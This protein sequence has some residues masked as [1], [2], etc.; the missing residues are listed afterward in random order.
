MTARVAGYIILTFKAHREGKQY[1]ARCEELGVSTC[2]KSLEQAF[3][4][5]QDA[6]TLY[7]T[8]IEEERERERVFAEHNITVHT[9]EPEH[10]LVPVCVRPDEDIVKVQSTPLPGLAYA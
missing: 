7:L 5:L 6:T 3:E 10:E 1:V 8:C 4:R 9:G 2:A